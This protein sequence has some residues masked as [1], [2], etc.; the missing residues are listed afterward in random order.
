MKKGCILRTVAEDLDID[1]YNVIKNYLKTEGKL[2]FNEDVVSTID[3]FLE[4]LAK[5]YESWEDIDIE[6]KDPLSAYSAFL[7]TEYGNWP[8]DELYEIDGN[9]VTITE[10]MNRELRSSVKWCFVDE[11]LPEGNLAFH[12]GERYR[13]TEREKYESQ[14]LY[15]YDLR[16]WDMSYDG[17]LGF[18][19]ELHVVANNEGSMVTN[20]KI[21]ELN[22]VHDFIEDEDF[23]KK[24]QPKH[25]SGLEELMEVM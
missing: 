5:D 3:W 4:Q 2:N 22:K 20:F 19:I 6:F 17:R 8:M 23:E 7:E 11:I 10:F 24:Y 9:D 14:G 1:S 21:E 25:V 12:S 18:N 13:G 16:T 15:F